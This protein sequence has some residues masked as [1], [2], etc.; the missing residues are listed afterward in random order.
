MSRTCQLVLVSADADVA[1]VGRVLGPGHAGQRAW[2]GDKASRS[3]GGDGGCL[4][5]ASGI[6][7]AGRREVGAGPPAPRCQRP[8]AR[9]AAQVSSVSDRP[10]HH[11][12]PRG[13][14]LA[15]DRS[16]GRVWP[17]A[18]TWL[19]PHVTGRG[20]ISHIPSHGG[21]EAVRDRNVEC[22]LAEPQGLSKSKQ[23]LRGDWPGGGCWPQ[24]SEVGARHTLAGWRAAGRPVP[25][26]VGSLWGHTPPTLALPLSLNGGRP[27]VRALCGRKGTETVLGAGGGSSPQAGQGS[28]RD[29]GGGRGCSLRAQEGLPGP[30]HPGC[31]GGQAT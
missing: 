31:T 17:G 3:P 14:S 19:E 2:R 25:S 10:A 9:D 23:A 30:G 28:V 7:R 6:A 18:R 20:L 1:S 16:A 11:L 27:P 13:P 21:S 15:E 24:H 4:G 8:E 22:P 26:W 5:L 12:A 29:P